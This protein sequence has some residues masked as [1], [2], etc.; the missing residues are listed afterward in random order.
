MGSRLIAVTTAIAAAGVLLAPAALAASPPPGTVQVTGSQL[1]RALLPASSFGS[2]FMEVVELDTGSSLKPTGIDKNVPALS[3]AGFWGLLGDPFFGQTANAWDDYSNAQAVVSG[4]GGT[5]LWYQQIIYQFARPGAA[6]SFYSQTYAKYRSCHS[7][8]DPGSGGSP[9]EYVTIRSVSKT[10]SGRFAAYQVTQSVAT[11]GLTGWLD[12]FTMF[13]VD[14]A[15]VFIFTVSGG[16]GAPP[17][18]PTLSAL[19]LR[20]IGRV[21]ALR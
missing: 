3:C 8:T 12:E 17:A 7:F 11:A 16:T 13:T 2:G 18:T 14:G 1:G 19:T 21:A 6:A 5:F 15:D 4:G 20:L 9:A 10:R